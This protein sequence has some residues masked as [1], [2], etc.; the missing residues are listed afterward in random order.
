M[1]TLKKKQ[2]SG[3]FV[4]RLKRSELMGLQQLLCCNI[5]GGA[6]TA[7]GL[8]GVI[9]CVAGPRNPE[10]DA[11][12]REATREVKYPQVVGRG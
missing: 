7:L 2:K 8:D 10:V 9:D 12:Y 1:A 5:T 11:E 4:L 3:D 6:V